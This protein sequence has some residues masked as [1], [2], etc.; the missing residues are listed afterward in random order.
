MMSSLFKAPT[1]RMSSNVSHRSFCRSMRKIV[2]KS[3]GDGTP[4]EP[5]PLKFDSIEDFFSHNADKYTIEQLQKP[6]STEVGVFIGQFKS[7]LDADSPRIYKAILNGFVLGR[8]EL[9]G[10][11]IE[12]TRSRTL[13]QV[14]E[15]L[16]S[17]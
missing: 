13:A 16:T 10:E 17:H 8:L 2:S 7:M 11:S 12:T 14:K 15:K 5:S 6:Y 4:I 3:V 9:D 1:M